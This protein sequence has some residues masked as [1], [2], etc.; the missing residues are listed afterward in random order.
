MSTKAIYPYAVQV[1]NGTV[2]GRYIVLQAIDS[3]NA[4]D[5]FENEYR[6]NPKEKVVSIKR[7]K[8]SRR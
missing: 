2:H 3:G 1:N 8:D 7:V 4:L 6:R 5:R